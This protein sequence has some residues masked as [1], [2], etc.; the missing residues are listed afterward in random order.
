M[1]AGRTILVVED[2]FDIREALIQILDA[3]G[4]PVAGASNGQE[5]LQYLRA[6]EHPRLILLDLMMP[7]MDGWQFRVEQQRDPTLSSIPVVVISAD[8]S[9][10]QKAASIDAA[11]FLKKPIDLDILLDTIRRCA[12]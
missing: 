7:I 8:A 4:Y 5:A 9:V 3:E 12:S 11:G 1:S 6:N 10:Q 2:D